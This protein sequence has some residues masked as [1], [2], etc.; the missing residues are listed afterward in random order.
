MN[1]EQI[2][3]L[4]NE[5]YNVLSE[6]EVLSENQ[7]QDDT[8][9]LNILIEEMDNRVDFLGD[10]ILKALIENVETLEFDFIFEQLSKLGSCPNLLNDDNGNWAV[11]TDGFQTLA[12]GDEPCDVDTHFSVPAN[13][14]KT[15]PRK[16]LI[17]YLKEL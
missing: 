13:N 14:W 9:N 5:R 17:H 7:N 12:Y 4:C 6:L 10:Q 15:T 2:S 16:A 11:V 3:H 8:E 1:K